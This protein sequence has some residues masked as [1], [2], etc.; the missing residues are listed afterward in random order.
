MLKLHE[1][2]QEQDWEL[3]RQSAMSTFYRERVQI[4]VLPFGF[5]WLDWLK[6]TA[7]EVN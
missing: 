2:T 3:T 7:T 1:V 5:G 4:D 6:I